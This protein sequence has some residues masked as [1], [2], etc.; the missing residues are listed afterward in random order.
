MLGFVTLT[1]RVAYFGV[2]LQHLALTKLGMCAK[3]K[4]SSAKGWVS[5]GKLSE[6]FRYRPKG[7]NLKIGLASA[8]SEEK[9]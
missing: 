5:G 9:E 2:K 1:P 3:I 8:E 4:V 7:S 6:K